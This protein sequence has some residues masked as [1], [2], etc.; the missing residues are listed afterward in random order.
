MIIIKHVFALFTVALFS[1]SIFSQ[2]EYNSDI[3]DANN[4][5]ARVYSCGNF[6]GPNNFTFDGDGFIINE[7]N[8]LSPIYSHALWISGVN[9]SGDLHLAADGYRSNQVKIFGMDL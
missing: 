4:V 6:F 9:S 3:L 1:C 2:I 5:E 7:T 8:S